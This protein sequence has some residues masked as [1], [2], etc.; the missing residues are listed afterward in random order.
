M[1]LDRLNNNQLPELTTV[2]WRISED[3]MDVLDPLEYLTR[4]LCGDTYASASMVI[5]SLKMVIGELE[6]LPTKTDEVYA[7]KQ[8]LITSLSTRFAA[9][10]TDER[11]SAA[12][13][14]DPRFKLAGFGSAVHTAT[15]KDRLL[16]E[17]RV[18]ILN[19]TVQPERTATI[20]VVT[21]QVAT[22]KRKFDVF[23][24]LESDV[25]TREASA[26]STSASIS[27]ELEGYLAY[28]RHGQDENVFA[29]WYGMKGQFPTVYRL[30]CKYLIIPATS[31]PSER[32][33]SVAG[34]VITQ[35]RCRLTSEHIN[36][37]VFLFTMTDKNN[38]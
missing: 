14:L 20:Q 26:S 23:A 35:H 34:N 21:T 19:D 12:T 1:A 9:C 33:F 36:Q 18:S 5:P 24:S 32:I 15:A 22:K 6:I 2:D 10:E 16:N 17:L 3:L 30:A 13:I 27:D 38:S 28:R 8:H 25:S 11:L 37:I 7:F 29:Y 4:I 31:A